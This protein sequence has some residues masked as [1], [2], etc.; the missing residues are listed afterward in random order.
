MKTNTLHEIEETRGLMFVLQ[1]IKSLL[2]VIAY[3]SWIIALLFIALVI[4]NAL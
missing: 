4:E 3:S 2:T 1:E